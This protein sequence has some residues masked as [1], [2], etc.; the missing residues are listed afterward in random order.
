[1]EDSSGVLPTKQLSL[2]IE[3]SVLVLLGYN[4]VPHTRWLI[5]R[6]VFLMV[7]EDGSLR[8]GYQVRALLHKG[9]GS[10][11]GCLFFFFLK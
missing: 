6:N 11:V 8:S 1:M 10:S 5:N 9:L 3:G 4:K 2:S 7:L